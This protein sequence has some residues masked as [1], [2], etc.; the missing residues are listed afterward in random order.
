MALKKRDVYPQK[1]EQIEDVSIDENVVGSS[2]EKE[3]ELI[4]KETGKRFPEAP[5]ERQGDGVA[6]G[7]V[8]A[9][10]YSK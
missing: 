9:G 2:E 10:Y 8:P 1:D 6:T 5:K 7:E 4:D 3:D